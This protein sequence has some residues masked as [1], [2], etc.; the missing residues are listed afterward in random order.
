MRRPVI[1]D[2]G[3][4]RE[5]NFRDVWS[6]NTPPGLNGCS[7]NSATARDPINRLPPPYLVPRKLSSVILLPLRFLPPRQ[8]LP[9]ARGQSLVL[10]PPFVAD[11][12]GKTKLRSDSSFASV[13]MYEPVI[14]YSLSKEEIIFRKAKEGKGGIDASSSARETFKLSMLCHVG[15]RYTRN[16][17]SCL[18]SNI[19]HG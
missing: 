13:C 7:F 3:E 5:S 10:H 6:D 14:V 12:D 8:F 4:K 2:G 15:A 1:E 19:S 9:L 16:V 11:F 17:R 18:E